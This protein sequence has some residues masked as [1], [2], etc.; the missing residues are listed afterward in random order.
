MHDT[1]T[2]NPLPG[3][4]SAVLCELI[5]KALFSEAFMDYYVAVEGFHF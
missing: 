3:Y 1:M 4:H 5:D 2:D